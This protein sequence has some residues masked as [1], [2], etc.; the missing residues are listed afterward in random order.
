[1]SRKSSPWEN[2]YQESFYGKF[3]FELGSLNRFESVG[4]AVEAIYQ[5]IHYY[6]D[7]RIHTTIRDI[8][9]NFRRRNAKLDSLILLSPKSLELVV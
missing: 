5:Q 6:N 8:P 9:A 4:H 3:K 7:K 2:G 1:M